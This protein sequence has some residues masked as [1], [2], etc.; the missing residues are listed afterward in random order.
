[1]CGWGGGPTAMF[2]TSRMPSVQEGGTLNGHSPAPAP[3]S[4]THVYNLELSTF[5]WSNTLCTWLLNCP[6]APAAQS[7]VLWLDSVSLRTKPLWVRR[8]L[9]WGPYLSVS[10][11][12]A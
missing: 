4:E 3:G 1:M 7:Y 2:T 6:L 12:G 10:P 11:A 9:F 8:R 5:P